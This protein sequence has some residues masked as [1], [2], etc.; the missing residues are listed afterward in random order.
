MFVRFHIPLCLN[1]VLAILLTVDMESTIAAQCIVQQETGLVLDIVC[2]RLLAGSVIMCK[3]TPFVITKDGDINYVGG[4][5]M[6]M[7][8]WADDKYFEFLDQKVKELHT[9]RRQGLITSVLR[10]L[11][12]SRCK[13]RRKQVTRIPPTLVTRQGNHTPQQP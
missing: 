8:Y 11:T 4:G 12:G 10:T 7:V 13:T 5:K 1:F 6:E 3:L 9:E 2:N